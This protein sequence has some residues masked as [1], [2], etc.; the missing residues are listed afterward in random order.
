VFNA[1]GANANAVKELVIAGMLLAARQIA[2]A[3]RFVAAL[4]TRWPTSTR[5]SS[6]RRRPSPATSWRGRRSASSAWARS[7]AS[8]PMPPS[9]WA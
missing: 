8:S 2:P 9:S 5:R 1:P 6:A 4:D 3:L 7:A